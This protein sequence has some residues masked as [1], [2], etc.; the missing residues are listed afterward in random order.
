MLALRDLLN[1]S[2][3]TAIVDVGGAYL[4][5]NPPYQRMLDEGV[6]TA[7]MIDPIGQEIFSHNPDLLKITGSAMPPDVV[8]Q[9][10]HAGKDKV[11]AHVSASFFPEYTFGP[12]DRG[13]R[14]LGLILHCFA[15]CYI[16][17][18]QSAGTIPHPDPHQIAQADLFYVKDFSKPMDVEQW[19][20]LAMLAHHVCGSYDL[21]MHAV[22]EL[23]KAGAIPED[24]AAQ[25]QRI[26][27]RL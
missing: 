11:A 18:I 1:P 8:L 12:L 10:L 22:S 14:E 9:V 7:E 20:H 3:M 26:L 13:L 24:G 27:E 16:T 6:C 4:Q 17:S 23:A 25:Y 15:D 21:A 5:G 2:R 19:K